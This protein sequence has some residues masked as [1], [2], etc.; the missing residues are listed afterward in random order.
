[1]P[2]QSYLFRDDERLQACL[3]HDP[4][5][6]TIGAQG[7]HVERVQAALSYLEGLAIDPVEMATKRYG[8][9]TASAVLS[10]KRKRKIINYAYQTQPDDIVGRMT[11]AAMDRELVQ[12]QEPSPNRLRAVCTRY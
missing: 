7:E 8:P 12:R 6:V 9:S 10:F 5:H 2:L 11:I 1:M 4:A 3:I